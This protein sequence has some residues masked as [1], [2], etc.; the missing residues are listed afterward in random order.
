M[1][2]K[3]I[4]IVGANTTLS[5]ALVTIDEK[6]VEEIESLKEMGIEDI[7]SIYAPTM[8]IERFPVSDIHIQKSGQ[9]KR[10]ERRKQNRS[11]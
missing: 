2:P 7:S 6:I 11:K 1:K 3:K 5:S 4:L 8:L 9:Q 10:R